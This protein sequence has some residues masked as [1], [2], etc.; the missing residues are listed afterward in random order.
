M[1]DKE[2]RY[3]SE[4]SRNSMADSSTVE[5]S[6]ASGCYHLSLMVRLLASG[7][8]V[9]IVMD[10][11]RDLIRS[12]LRSSWKGRRHPYTYPHTCVATLC[13]HIHR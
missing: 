9:A 7:E 6:C 2:M 12:I 5:S 10:G 11:V 13:L 4:I 8:P 3:V 1:C